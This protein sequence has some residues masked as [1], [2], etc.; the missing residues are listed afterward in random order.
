MGDTFGDGNSSEKPV[1]TITVS[2][3]W[4]SKY[5][6]TQKEWV[7]VMGNNSSYFEG[8]NLPV[9]AVS[10]YDVIEY[11]NIRSK[12]EGLTPCY[13]I[14]KI[15]KDPNNKSKYDNLKWI[16]TVNWNANGYRLPTEAEWE[17]AA[18]GGNKSKGYKYSG[19]N[20][21]N[22]VGWYYNKN[23]EINIF[24]GGRKMPNELGIY[25]MSGNVQEWCW[26]WYDENYY[27]YSPTNDPKGPSFSR[28]RVSRGG[29]GEYDSRSGYHRVTSRNSQNPSYNS[30]QAE[31]GKVGFRLVRSAQ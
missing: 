14:D 6:V 23:L 7:E 27:N 30:P 12:K 17:Y 16:I 10:W 24:S 31:M 29:C 20:N 15:K 13:N 28:W 3:F 26:D 5:E 21:I 25:D 19:S 1:H 8:D 18:R 2:S 11:C 4:I 9:Y 22:D